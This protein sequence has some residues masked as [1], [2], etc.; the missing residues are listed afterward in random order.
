[1]NK[2]QVIYALA[3]LGAIVAIY[4]TI[5]KY[6]A[7]VLA[8]P[9]SGL[10]NCESVITSQYSTIF[11]I[12]TSVLGLVL[13]VL[14]PIMLLRRNDT[15][16]FLWSIAGTGAIMYSL[17]A[18]ALLSMVCLYCLSMD[19]MIAALILVSYYIKEV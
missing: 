1:M 13:F 8:C 10:I 14:A 11:G 17:G 4:L 16:Q 15:T 6:D 2:K 19:V 9:E 7:S 3:I 12:P 18:Q 5:S